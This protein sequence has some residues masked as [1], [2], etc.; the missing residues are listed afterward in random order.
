MLIS[1][2]I[3]NY[4]RKLFQEV[5][6]NS[7]KTWTKINEILNIKCNAKS[8]IFLSEKDHLITNQILVANKF[9]NYFVNVS[10]D[11]FKGLG[12]TNNQFR[13]YL[14]ILSEQSFILRETQP[15]EV[16]GVLKKV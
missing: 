12:E 16:A 8:N 14:K 9:N 1:K 2:S 15:D 5:K 11:L 6:D 13:D 3:R 7:K 10:Q 4:L